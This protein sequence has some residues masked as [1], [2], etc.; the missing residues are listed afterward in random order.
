MTTAPFSPKLIKG[1]LVLIGAV[2]ARVLRIVSLPYN[3]DTLMR[4][5]Q[6]QEAGGDSAG[7]VEPIRFKG[8]AIETISF[9]AKSDATARSLAPGAPRA[10]STER[11]LAA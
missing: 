2:S 9:E 10:C 7:R 6:A 11:S 4:K 8:P 3:A 5:L 1:G